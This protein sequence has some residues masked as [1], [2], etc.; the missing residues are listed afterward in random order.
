MVREWWTFDPLPPEKFLCVLLPRT[1]HVWT[2]SRGRMKCL[3]HKTT[4]PSVEDFIARISVT[5]RRIRDMPGI[6][7]NMRNSVPRRCQICQKTSGRNFEH[8]L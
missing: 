6:F 2:S 7:Q 3:M 8:L 4:F 5:D 1:Y